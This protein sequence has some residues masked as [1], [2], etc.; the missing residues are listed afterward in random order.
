MAVLAYD[1]TN[2]HGFAQQKG[3][4]TVCGEL[5]RAIEQ[6][7]ALNTE[8][9]CAGR[10]DKGVHALGQV[11]HF[12]LPSIELE[13]IDLTR[14][15]RSLNAMIGPEIS[16]L[17]LKYVDKSFSARHSA[18]SRLYRYTI[19]NSPVT[20]PFMYRYAWYVEQSLDLRAMILGCDALIG[21]HD[22]SS[23]CKR[24]PGAGSNDPIIRQVL[25]AGWT[26]NGATKIGDSSI[27]WPIE[28]ARTLNF[29]ILASSFCHQMV[30]SVVGTLVAMGA[31]KRKAGEMTAIIRAKN[32]AVAEP[33]APPQGLYLV[34]VA[35]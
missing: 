13:R 33:P 7:F 21:E 15:A 3:L 23:F 18:K 32:R 1:G 28:F 11:V 8:V 29:E 5:V 6:V 10:T 34:E 12:D 19:V 26:T 16:V 24:P 9:I 22:F 25:R 17:D 30:R 31:G 27:T 14:L 2:F 4:R 35:Y 20:S